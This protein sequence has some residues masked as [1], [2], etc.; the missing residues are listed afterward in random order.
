M[1]HAAPVVRRLHAALLHVVE[2]F[3]VRLPDVDL[4]ARERPA[5]GDEHPPGH[6]HWIALAVEA[7]IRAVR[8]VKSLSFQAKGWKYVETM[9]PDTVPPELYELAADP[10]E[11]ENLFESRGDMAARIR[12]MM[13]EF[14]EDVPEGTI[15]SVTIDEDTL[16][17]LRKMGYVGGGGR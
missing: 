14:L 7:Q 9:V 6:E 10:G 1:E 11:L 16:E 4:H 17:L 2:A 15:K 5:V 8:T 13:N 12:A 3:L